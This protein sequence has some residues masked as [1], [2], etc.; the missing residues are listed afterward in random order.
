[1]ANSGVQWLS[2]NCR[3]MQLLPLYLV[4]AFSLL[5]VTTGARGQSAERGKDKEGKDEPRTDELR[6]LNESA[7]ALVKKV[8]PSVVQ[9]LVTGYGPLEE[10]A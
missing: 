3:F 8:S 5:L 2:R 10:V 6:K 4:C 7:A 1:M 9:I